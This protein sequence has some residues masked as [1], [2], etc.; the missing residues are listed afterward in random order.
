MK[1]KRSPIITPL[2]RDF[3]LLRGDPRFQKLCEEKL[4]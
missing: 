4:K 3:D 1:T 2:G